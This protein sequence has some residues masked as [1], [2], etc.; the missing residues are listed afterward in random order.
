MKTVQ[1]IEL[2]EE[3]RRLIQDF[4]KLTDEMSNIIGCSMYDVFE[5]LAN[6]TEYDDNIGKYVIK[7]LHN[8]NEINSFHNTSY[9]F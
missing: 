8:I 7:S 6:A 4:M 2:T 3:E 1:T 5:Y 9:P